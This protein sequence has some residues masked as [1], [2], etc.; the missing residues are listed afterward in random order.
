MSTLE[1]IVFD[2][3]G[4]ILHSLPDLVACANEASSRMRFPSRS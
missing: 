3:D 2:M 4:T 1:A